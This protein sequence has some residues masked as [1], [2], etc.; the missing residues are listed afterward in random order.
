MNLDGSPSS[1]AE[2]DTPQQITTPLSGPTATI[3][4]Y[5]VLSLILTYHL[6]HYFESRNFS[7][8]DLLWKMLVYITPSSLV[9]AFDKDF[10]KS[11]SSE[12]E[13]DTAKSDSKDHAGKGNAMRR[14]L[15]LELGG[16]TG[17]VHRTRTLSNLGGMLKKRPIN[18]PP[19]LG[20]WD[21][22]CYQNA[23]LQGLASLDSLPTFLRSAGEEDVES[24]TK[25]A[26][27]KLTARLNAADNVGKTF[28]TPAK[29]KNMSSWQQQDAQEYLSKVL[30]EVEKDVVR[31][32]GERPKTCGFETLSAISPKRDVNGEELTKKE[33]EDTQSSIGTSR[34]NLLPKELTAVMARN[35]LEGLLAQRV[36]CQKCGYVEGLS[37]VPFNCLTVPL[38]KERSYDLRT[39][40][41]DFTALEPINGVDCAKCT[42]L[43]AESHM[44]QILET[45][46]PP[47]DD[48]D[49]A[50]ISQTSVA[51]CESV[52]KRLS[53]VRRA[54]KDQEFSENA[55][56]K[57]QIGAKNR[58]STT[59]SRQ[60]IVARPPK[61]LVIHINRSVF[62]E[63]T[64]VQSKNYANVR[65][66][67]RFSI[68]PWCLGQLAENVETWNTDP[69][70]SMLSDLPADQGQSSEQRPCYELRAVI[71][72][73]GR[74]EN[75]HYVCYRR[76]PQKPENPNSADSASNASSPWW[77]LSDE[78]VT[79]VREESVLVQAGV[80]MLFYEQKEPTISRAPNLAPSQTMEETMDQSRDTQIVSESHGV[81]SNEMRE[82]IDTSPGPSNNVI[83]TAVTPAPPEAP[84]TVV[85]KQDKLVTNCQET[86][87]EHPPQVDSATATHPAPEMTLEES[88]SP[89]DPPEPLDPESR[90]QNDQCSSKVTNTISHPPSSQPALQ[91]PPPDRSE[92][93]TPRTVFQN[94][95]TSRSGRKNISGAGRA[96]ES[97]AGCVQAN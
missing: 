43:Q 45:L 48:G 16:L 25:A 96:M 5:A 33:A 95:I 40:L 29:L 66:P 28:W 6:L 22:S 75:G 20:N 92:G 79:P 73:Y 46:R 53:V 61:A 1:F 52:E 50:S 19:G 10:S 58:V 71:T 78:N 59:K 60:A 84:R 39:C 27:G 82:S 69:S 74:H 62:N 81:E 89:D 97:V 67:Q 13:H 70:Q 15:G 93:V 31:S 88:S 68:G 55:L 7:F 72:H 11:L 32:I 8:T 87:D 44:L 34:L 49:Q 64:G 83:T 77:R 57:C 35:P 91:S 38:G 41:D 85:E 56:K 37:L 18:S 4:A 17:I 2:S 24:S 54:V 30:D 3:S 63:F 80:F 47:G 90:A 42:L 14:I 94:P 12:A 65:F 51:L 23:V 9:A 76:S 86:V 26:L 21:N 36:G